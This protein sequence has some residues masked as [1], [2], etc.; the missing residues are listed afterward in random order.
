MKPSSTVILMLILSA[1]ILMAKPATAAVSNP[2]VFISRQILDQGSVFYSPAKALPGVGP[3]SRFRP[4][5]PGKLLV[6]EVNGNTRV[7]VDDANP[8]GGSLNLID[9]NAPNVSYDGQRIIF[10]G[11]PAPASGQ[12]YPTATGEP[13]GAWRL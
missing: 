13:I 3:H 7:L 11:L 1:G 10:S 9:V 2:V 6:R 12:S 8:T 4:A 5:S